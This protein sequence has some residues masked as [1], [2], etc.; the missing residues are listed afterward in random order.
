MLTIIRHCIQLCMPMQISKNHLHQTIR[1]GFRGGVPW[2]TGVQ[3]GG[4][5]CKRS[6][7]L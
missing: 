2:S 4:G 3:G 7:L 6:V 1:G 5:V